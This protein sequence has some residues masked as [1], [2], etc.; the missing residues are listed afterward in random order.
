MSDD[1]SDLYL[2]FSTNLIRLHNIPLNCT[3]GSPPCH[4]I[5]FPPLSLT[6]TKFIANL[7]RS[8]AFSPHGY[9][10]ITILRSCL[11]YSVFTLKRIKSFPY[12][13]W[14]LGKLGLDNH[15][16]IVMSSFV[17]SSVFKMFA[18]LRAKYW[19]NLGTN[20]RESSGSRRPDRLVMRPVVLA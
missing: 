18:E 6:C 8:C 17:Q 11:L 9:S 7:L 3:L 4:M 12:S 15:M 1:I 5:N 10:F 13:V 16:V 20:S 2:I 14:R 19:R